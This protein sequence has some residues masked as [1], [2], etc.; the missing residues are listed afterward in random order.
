[1][2]NL[3]TAGKNKLATK[4]KSIAYTESCL[5][6]PAKG[7][8]IYHDHIFENSCDSYRTIFCHQHVILTRNPPSKLFYCEQQ[9]NV[10]HIP[11]INSK[12]ITTLLPRL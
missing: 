6:P 7:P 10:P 5:L 4:V 3:G 9:F 11:T 1:M 2:R 8:T 12:T